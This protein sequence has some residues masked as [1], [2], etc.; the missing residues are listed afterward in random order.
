MKMCI[1]KEIV[2]CLTKGMGCLCLNL[3]KFKQLST[4]YFLGSLGGVFDHVWD[5][6]AF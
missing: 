1:D 2:I 5:A 3:F 4:E 6:D